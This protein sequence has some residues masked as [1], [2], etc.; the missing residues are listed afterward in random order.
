MYLLK[1]TNRM[2]FMIL[3]FFRRKDIALRCFDSYVLSFRKTLKEVIL[4]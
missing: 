1:S 3:N 2:I 4:V